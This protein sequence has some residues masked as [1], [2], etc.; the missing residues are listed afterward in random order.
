MTEILKDI[1]ESWQALLVILAAIAFGG[2]SVI[3]IGEYLGLPQQVEAIEQRSAENTALIIQQREDFD[4]FLQRFDEFL[5]IQQSIQQ[6]T[7]RPD[8]LNVTGR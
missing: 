5:C 3:V 2:G 4:A 6:G 7:P 8:C 1:K